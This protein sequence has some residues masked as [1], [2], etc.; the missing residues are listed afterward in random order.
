MGSEWK[1]VRIDDV[2]EINPDYLGKDWPFDHIL[3][4][5]ISSVGVGCLTLPPQRIAISDVPDR[6]KRLVKEGDTVLS[7]VRP[8]RRSMFWAAAP[9]S[10]WI[11]STGFAVLRPKKNIIEP[12]FLYSCVFNPAFTK[13]LISREKGAAYPAVSPRDISDAVIHLPPLP[14]QRAIACILGALDDKIEL[15]RRMSRTLE[16]MARAIF[17]SWFIDFEPVRA[18]AAV[19][20]LHPHWTDDQVSR[21]ACPNLKPE[22]ARLFPDSFQN[23]ELGEIPRG[24]KVQSFTDGVEVIGGGTPKTSVPEFWGGK[25]PWFSVADTP[26]P[27]NVFVISTEKTITTEGLNNSSARVLPVGTT[28]ISARGTVG[29]LAL[30]GVPMAMNQSCYG[31]HPRYG[32]RGYYLYFATSALVDMLRQRAHGSV[33]STITRETLT[34]TRVI[35]PPADLIKAFERIAS[36]QLEQL[37]ANQHQIRVLSA[38]RDTLLPKLL[39]GELPIKNAE[40][41]LKARGL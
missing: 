37:L 36:G 25:I 26:P 30:V 33:F 21:A 31:L 22:I 18:K 11:V 34:S 16:E 39:S 17:K 6:A 19:R 28:I 14:V 12:R 40:K 29:N 5:D 38:L 8:N 9:G 13:Y 32:Y 7:T 23:S 27:G 35:A 24:W 10:D 2:A 20:R 4:I 1:T 3:Y 15:N 41:F